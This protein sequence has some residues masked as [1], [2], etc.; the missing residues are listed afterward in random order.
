MEKNNDAMDTARY[1]KELEE[2][3]DTLQTLLNKESESHAEDNKKYAGAFHQLLKDLHV[4]VHV[5][6]RLEREIQPDS[7]DALGLVEVDIQV[8]EDIVREFNK[9]HDKY[10]DKG[11]AFLKEIIRNE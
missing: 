8:A 7:N 3:V 4:V 1:Q 6:N 11:Y 5:M 10:S 9:F 2:R